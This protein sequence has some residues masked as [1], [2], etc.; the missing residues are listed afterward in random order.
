MPEP[1]SPFP[2]RPF[3][4]PSFIS[5]IRSDPRPALPPS[6]WRHGNIPLLA[7]IAS[8]LAA[9]FIFGTL[10]GLGIGTALGI[11]LYT[12]AFLALRT[13]L[14]RKEQAFLI[15]MAL[16][17]AAATAVNLSPCTHFNLLIGMLLPVAITF[18]P[19]KKG[20]NF[21]P[22]KRY[23]SWWGY[24]F[25]HLNQAKEAAGKA[26]GKI[27]LAGSVII[28]VVLF[29]VFLSI[30][31]DG[32]PVV[33]AVRSAMYTWFRQYCSWLV[34]DLG[35]V[36][37][38]LLWCLGALAFGIATKPRPC[39]S[40]PEKYPVHP[41][42]PWLPS[43][44]AISLLFINLAFLVNNGTDVAFLWRG[45]VPDGISQTAYL[46]EGAD[47]IMLAAFLSALVLL[48]LFRP[49]GSIRSSKTGAVLGFI[50]AAQT[51]LLAASVGMRLY[52]QIQDF[53][54]SPTRVTAG[55]YLLMGACFLYL[56][57]RYM[58]SSGNWLRYGKNCGALALVVM[59]L[60]GFRSPSQL[61]GDLNLMTM[62]GHEDWYFSDGDLP[63]FELPYN[64]PFAMAVYL[65]LGGDTE[66]GANVYA[67]IRETLNSGRRIWNWRSFNLQ[68]W[69]RDRQRQRFQ[70][71]PIPTTQATYGTNAW[72]PSS[73]PTGMRS[74]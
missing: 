13:D 72:M 73:R 25:F 30:F 45:S 58:A 20:N 22:A 15:F 67:M 74:R 55:I 49:E 59:A 1:S 31:A 11:L 52:Y 39:F 46:H 62:D 61:S 17:N 64:L 21:D 34:P 57:F 53:G 63:R 3:L 41:S 56:L 6:W 66:E 28:G 29:F 48:V 50:L 37:D 26:A 19:R 23:V 68:K 33:A 10:E 5:I 38:I 44:P 51:G 18:L 40:F 71:L 69:N 16:L 2:E 47:S 27:P 24:K 4:P 43:L 35:T 60:A 54:F 32:N 14:S 65:R 7:L 70:Q 8:G 36:A 42:R 9:D 12:A